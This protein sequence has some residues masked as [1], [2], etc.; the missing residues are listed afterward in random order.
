MDLVLRASAKGGKPCRGG[1]CAGESRSGRRDR[2]GLRKGGCKVRHLG[3]RAGGRT[4]AQRRQPLS[5]RRR[6]RRLGGLVARGRVVGAD[7]PTYLSRAAAEGR[8]LPW[9]PAT[10]QPP[11]AGAPGAV[12]REPLKS[13][14][15]VAGRGTERYWR[16]AEHGC[17]WRRG[18]ER[19][20]LVENRATLKTEP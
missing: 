15:A 10:Y 12:G 2:Y 5:A 9:H 6:A 7:R 19:V 18:R 20:L 3:L 1:P 17:C 11:Q 16:K 4:R 8:P 13:H 14:R